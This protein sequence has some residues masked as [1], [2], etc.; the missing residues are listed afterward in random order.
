MAP[1]STPSAPRTTLDALRR[2]SLRG[3][4]PVPAAPRA[5]ARPPRPAALLLAALALA[6]SP[7]AP[8]ADGDAEVR[9]HVARVGLDANDLPVV[10]LGEEDGPRWLP[11]WIGSAEARSIALQIEQR[12]S[13]RPNS[14]DLAQRVIAGL[15]GAVERVVVTDLRAGTYYATLM[16][17]SGGR[18]VEIDSRPSDAI[19]IA[20]R[21]EA[22]IFV[23]A[24]LF[25]EAGRLPD[26][27]P[28]GEE[29]SI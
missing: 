28:A 6:C 16:L 26:D 27:A 12:P 15:R 9:V 4:P 11:I 14:H 23:R 5:P 22:P 1:A 2:L 3:A 25:E 10:L 29:K 7:D 18:R 21:A 13:P 19:A 20:L 17:R 8:G 24:R